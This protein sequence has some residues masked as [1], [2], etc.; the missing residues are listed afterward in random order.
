MTPVFQKPEDN[1]CNNSCS[2]IIIKY[3][4]LDKE[5]QANGWNYESWIWSLHCPKHQTGKS[6]SWSSQPSMQLQQQLSQQQSTLAPTSVSF[7]SGFNSS[8]TYPHFTSLVKLIEIHSCESYY[9]FLE[10]GHFVCPDVH[11][12]QNFTDSDITHQIKGL[13]G[14]VGWNFVQFDL[15]EGVPAH[16]RGSGM[17]GPL[18][19][20]ST[21]TVPWFYVFVKY[22]QQFS[23][24]ILVYPPIV[25]CHYSNILPVF[26]SCSSSFFHIPQYALSQWHIFIKYSLALVCICQKPL[27][28][29]LQMLDV[30]LTIN[31]WRSFPV[32][33]PQSIL[34]L[35]FVF[36]GTDLTKAIINL[37][38]T[39]SPHL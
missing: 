34:I 14:Q 22:I 6:H 20:L 13:Q 1:S 11:F 26:F 8:L 5:K 12:A 9:T 21:Q 4:I 17:W 10:T 30:V 32:I 2:C 37:F 39:R 31:L 3:F 29:A 19:P 16:S 35:F 33:H 38:P 7:C 18:M 25:Y 15:R 24:V 28:S 27:L 36:T 23:P